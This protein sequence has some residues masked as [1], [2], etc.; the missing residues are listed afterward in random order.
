MSQT[1]A[2]IEINQLTKIYKNGFHALKGINLT[3]QSGEFFGLLGVNGAGK[4]TMIGIICSLVTKTE[5]KVKINGYDIDSQLAKA[6]MQ[7]GVVPQEFNFHSFET[8]FQIVTNQALY[9]GMPYHKA[10]QRAEIVLKQVDLWEKC[11]QKALTLSGGMKRRLMIARAL[12]HEPN[13]LILDEPT[14]GVDVEIRQA[15]WEQIKK[16]NQDGMTIILTSHYLEEVEA[17]CERIAIIHQGQIIENFG[18]KDFIEKIS[19]ESTLFNFADVIPTSFVLPNFIW[20]KIN[21]YSI[22]V[23]FKRDQNISQLLELLLKQ[24]IVVQ[25]IS[26]QSNRLEKF[27]LNRIKQA[28]AEV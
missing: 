13:I 8:P 4:S 26:N 5:G 24:N 1:N 11:H 16:L 3:I 6:K 17:M 27:F 23:D 9:Y 21:D 22:E 28:K 18:K 15:I 10:K 7:L 2:A 12:V 14:A 20:R 19:I 25:R